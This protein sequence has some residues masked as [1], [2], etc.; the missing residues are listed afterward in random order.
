ME[1]FLMGVGNYSEQDVREAAR[2]FT[3]WIDDDLSFR[4]DASKHDGRDKT[5]LGRTGPFDG[6]EVLDIILGSRR[7]RSTLPRKSIASSCGTTH[8]PNYRRASAPCCGRPAIARAVP[9][10]ALVAG[11]LQLGL[12][13]S[14][15]QGTGRIDRVHLPPAW[16]DS[17][18]GNPRHQQRQW[19]A[20]TGAAQSPDRRRL[21]AGASLDHTGDLHRPRQFRS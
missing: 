21:G 12:D 13:G 6:V 10:D 8:R 15:D 20:R 18:A 7:P 5:F 3:G 4:F 11:F 19:R 16:P 9:A 14:T 17:T 2:A 1:L